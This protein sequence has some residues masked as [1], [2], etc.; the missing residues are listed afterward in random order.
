MPAGTSLRWFQTL[1]STN[2]AALNAL[3]CPEGTV[4]A[5]DCQES[6][7]GRLGRSWHSPPGRNLYFSLVLYPRLC[8]SQWGGFSLAAGVGLAEGIAKLGLCPE[9]KWP[10][11][12][13][14]RGRKLSGI[15]LEAKAEKLVVGIGVNVNQREFPDY[16]VAASL[17]QVADKIWRRDKLLPHFVEEVFRWCKLWEGGLHQRVL[18]A[19]QQY[20]VLIGNKVTAC[21]GEERIQGRAEAV[22]GQGELVVIGDNGI[23]HYFHSGEVTLD[24]GLRE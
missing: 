6:G 14:I 11:D 10:N 22:G 2:A 3:N 8:L 15:L 5:A 1:P 7:R 16:L 4:F 19:W 24:K 23:R 17:S 20:D 21:R 18:S 13:L 12:L 9:L